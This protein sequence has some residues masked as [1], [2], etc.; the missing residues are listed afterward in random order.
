MNRSQIMLAGLLL[1]QLL[2][3]LLVRSP[4]ASTGGASESETLLPALEVITP[5]R[6]EL[7]GADE[8]TVTL[9][10]EGGSWVS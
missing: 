1:V 8:A 10:N 5:S 6:I 4:F 3:I 9:S 7:F 2:L